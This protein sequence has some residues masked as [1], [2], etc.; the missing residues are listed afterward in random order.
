MKKAALQVVVSV[1]LLCF[2]FS[3]ALKWMSFLPVD[4][5]LLFG[6]AVAVCTVGRILSKSFIRKLEEPILLWNLTF[7][8]LFIFSATTSISDTF[9]YTK[10]AAIL[11][12]IL[13][14]V[15]PLALLEN[16][17]NEGIFIVT[18][19]YFTL[20]AAMIVH[21]FYWTGQI[22]T[23]HDG[24]NREYTKLP[25]YLVL[26]Y[27]AGLNIVISALTP[28]RSSMFQLAASG[29]ALVLL[30]G[31]GPAIFVPVTLLCAFLIRRK[32]K[33]LGS[34]KIALSITTL[35]GIL[36]A[37]L[38][39]WEGGEV[40]LGRLL[41]SYDSA[42]GRIADISRQEE[43]IT[44]LRVFSASPLIGTGIGGYGIAA[45]GLDQNI[46]P[47]NILV[48]A[49]VETGLVGGL[50]FTLCIY[51]T[52]RSSI[53]GRYTAVGLVLASCLFYTLLNYMKSGGF[54]GA[55]DYYLFAGLTIGYSSKVV[56]MRE[57]TSGQ[58][59]LS[60]SDS[61]AKGRTVWRG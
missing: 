46:Y 2:V 32:D 36:L 1:L 42:S 24:T 58:K 39:F 51:M 31:R 57:V 38:M 3:G 61:A 52:L 10:L 19:Q 18:L 54:I 48:E 34:T 50:L 40:L 45:H 49:F 37:G 59:V 15:A 4:P 27:L 29:S 6:G 5:T 56:R 8:F 41:S 35:V 14:L 13:A 16:E 7:L 28:S 43:F 60:R 55:R 23:I 17:Q 12:N 9:K 21:Y 44:A 20:L 25:D 26:G 33:K 30:S 47:H 11:L 53:A 22:A